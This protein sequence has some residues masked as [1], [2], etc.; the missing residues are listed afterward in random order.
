[1]FD[2]TKLH[3]EYCVAFVDI[4]GFKSMT[5]KNQLTTYGPILNDAIKKMK[6]L[7][8]IR[9]FGSGD[10]SFKYN[11]HT[12]Q[13]ADSIVLLFPNDIRCC[14]LSMSWLA[15]LQ[16]ELAQKG[17]FLR[18]AICTGQ[19]YID[20]EEDIYYG[21]AWN[22]AVLQEG[23]AIHPRI[24]LQNNFAL[25]VEEKLRNIGESVFEFYLSSDGYYVLDAYRECFW[26]FGDATYST[27]YF[28]IEMIL[29]SVKERIAYKLDASILNKYK[30]LIEEL[31][32]ASADKED[33]NKKAKN[34][35]EKIEQKLS[36]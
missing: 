17:V 9:A 8:Q 1:M 2:N 24:I 15:F 4:L 12:V 28:G 34:L 19:M 31:I 16:F 18:G 36:Q 35:K 23:K 22:E 30:W 10:D 25:M 6:T 3:D 33:V 13:F 20:P 5:S 32:I 29:I 21:E 27:K 7:T 26:M 11:I 14:L